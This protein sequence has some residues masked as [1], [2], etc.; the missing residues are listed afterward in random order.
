VA[1]PTSTEDR[2]ALHDLYRSQCADCSGRDGGAR[3]ERERKAALLAV[4]GI[5]PATYGGV[6]KGCGEAY[7]WGEPIRHS[8]MSQGWVG[9]CCLDD[10]GVTLR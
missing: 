7:P 2:C 10:R 6:C 4:R 8:A 5:I 1:D 9:S 3:A